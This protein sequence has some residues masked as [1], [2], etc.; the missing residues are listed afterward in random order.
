[1]LL[2]D[3]PIYSLG[4]AIAGGFFQKIIAKNTTVPT[5]AHHVFTTVKDNQ[6]SAKITVVQGESEIAAQNE[7]LGEF[8]LTG[9]RS[10]KRG[11]VDIDVIFDISADGIVS[12]SAIDVQTGLRQSITVTASSGLTEDEIKRAAADNEEWLLGQ[13]EDPQIDAR[14]AAVEKLIKE[15]EEFWPQLSAA[16]SK[17]LGREALQSAQAALSVAR[18]QIEQRDLAGLAASADRLERMLAALR[19]AVQRGKPPGAAWAW[20]PPGESSPRSSSRGGTT[21]ARARCWRPCVPGR[22][23]TCS[24]RPTCARASSSARRWSESTRTWAAPVPRPRR[25]SS[26]GWPRRS[27]SRSGRPRS[28]SPRPRPRSRGGRTRGCRQPGPTHPRGS[29]CPP[30]RGTMARRS[31]SRR[32]PRRTA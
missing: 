22:R 17:G 31:P 32:S 10:A 12:V 24:S 8:M 3:L 1:M 6:T 5:S 18:L 19:G 28:R 9:L 11:D 30:R 25:R 27:R 29:K 21:I 26:P 13:K 15:F 16:A 4:I 23:R 2:L 7:L 20:D 14:K